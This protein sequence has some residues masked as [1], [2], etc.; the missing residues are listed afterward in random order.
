MRLTDTVDIGGLECLPGVLDANGSRPSFFSLSNG[1][2]LMSR[3]KY[4]RMPMRERLGAVPAWPLPTLATLSHWAPCVC[5]LASIVWTGFFTSS[6]GGYVS[7]YLSK[8]RII[9]AHE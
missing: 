4:T 9:N 3:G 8:P 7:R 2:S 1:G 6:S 5:A